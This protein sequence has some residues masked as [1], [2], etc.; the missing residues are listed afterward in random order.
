MYG[1]H[2][3]GDP[4]YSWNDGSSA[5]YGTISDVTTCKNKCSKREECGG[6]VMSGSICAFWTRTPLNPYK[7]TDADC[8]IKSEGG[9]CIYFHIKNSNITSYIFEHTVVFNFQPFFE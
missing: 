5:N 6:F 2:C 4:I 7:S 3:G 9:R 8:F 1:F